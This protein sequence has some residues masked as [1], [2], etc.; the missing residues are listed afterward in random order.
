MQQTLGLITGYLT[1]A[2]NTAQ[3]LAQR[4]KMG[5]CLKFVVISIWAVSYWGLNNDP[6]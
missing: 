4:K 1:M 5:G 2:L 3:W 6:G